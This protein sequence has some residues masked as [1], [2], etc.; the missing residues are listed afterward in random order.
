VL[1]PPPPD[2]EHAA[3]AADDAAR[4]AQ[5]VHRL[6][7]SFS[8]LPDEPMHARLADERI[9]YFTTTASTSRATSRACR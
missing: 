8:K 5:H 7:Y 4:R 2:D 6:H 3:L 9:G 1:P